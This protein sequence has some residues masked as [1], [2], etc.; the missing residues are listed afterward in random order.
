MLDE[1]EEY[2]MDELAKIV[3]FNQ[4][5]TYAHILANEGSQFTDPDILKLADVDGWTVAHEMALQGYAFKDD[6]ILFLTT[7]NGERVLD[8]QN[9][10][11]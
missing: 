5:T 6:K 9:S 7:N 4:G 3:D 2:T 11:K 1:Y 8:V 10:D